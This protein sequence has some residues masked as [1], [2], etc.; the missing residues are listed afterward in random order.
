M[1]NHAKTPDEFAHLVSSLKDEE[2]KANQT[3]ESAKQKAVDIEKGAREQAIKI[4][5]AAAEE[6]VSAKNEI[7]ASGKKKMDDDTEKVL[8]KAR[9]EAKEIKAMR[10]KADLA[11]AMTDNLISKHRE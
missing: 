4:S 1:H 8:T 7:L 5:T 3:I 6:A 9:G 2:K 10:I 11:K